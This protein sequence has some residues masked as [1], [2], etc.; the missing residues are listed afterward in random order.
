MDQRGA[1]MSYL[2]RLLVT[3][4]GLESQDLAF[5]FNPSSKIAYFSSYNLSTAVQLVAQ[6]PTSKIS[7]YFPSTNSGDLLQN[8][9]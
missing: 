3:K 2:F 8:I 6:S 9:E 5:K 7:K 4:P 1:E